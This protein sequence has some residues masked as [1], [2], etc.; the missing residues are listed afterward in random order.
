[1]CLR[2]RLASAIAAAGGGVPTQ[3][4]EAITERIF[5]GIT[6]RLVA[7]LCLSTMSALIESFMSFTVSLPNGLRQRT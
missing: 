7:I 4:S 1:M 5:L 6:L 3:K 2:L